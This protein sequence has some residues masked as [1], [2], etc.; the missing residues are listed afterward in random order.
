MR[1]G[2]TTNLH[3]RKII[4][5]PPVESCETLRHIVS[6]IVHSGPRR[7]RVA[8]REQFEGARRVSH[9]FVWIDVS[10]GRVVDGDQLK[11]IDVE[12]F[13]EFIGNANLVA[14]IARLELIVSNANIL[15][16]VRMVADAGRF[17]I[18]HLTAA[19]EI[20]HELESLAVPGIKIRT[21]RRLAVKLSDF[22]CKRGS[23]RRA[24]DFGFGLN[25][26]RGPQ[27]SNSI[28]AGA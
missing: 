28:D 8:S 26:S 21:R 12:Y 18:A 7:M 2:I 20:S 23:C 17:Q 3:Q 10:V 27:D 11:P 4:W 24:G 25:D 22:Q 15:V 14:T 9:P 5:I 19:H 6:A 13:F 16:G 1:L